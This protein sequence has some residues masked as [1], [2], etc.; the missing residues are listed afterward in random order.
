MS[1]LDLTKSS[2]AT[3]SEASA[4]L[5]HPALQRN[6]RTV[7]KPVEFRGLSLF[8]GYDTT[9]KLLPADANTGIVF[10]R[11]DICDQPDILATTEYL[12][13]EPR[14]TVLAS[15]RSCRVETV[16]HLMAA[17]AGLQIDNCVI[18]INTPEMPSY[19]G[20]SIAFC[21]GILDAGFDSLTENVDVLQVGGHQTVRSSDRKQSLTLRPYLFHCTAITYHFDYGPR[22]LVPPQ[23]LSVEITPDV[24]YAEIAGAR[25]FILESEIAGLKKLGFGQHLT[26]RDLVVIGKRGPIEN[27]LRWADEGVRH[28]ILDCVG[29]LAL[30]GS[31]FHGHIAASRS[32]HH[33]NHEMAK[34]LTMMKKSA[35]LSLK[36]A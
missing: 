5:T 15:S 8:H 33:L 29:D 2:K 19:D 7:C 14:R 26:T 20:S 4:F 9:V 27:S 18:E 24:F 31:G 25:T 30:C 1:A 12:V 16:E 10:R 22:S 28:K 13:T 11:T 34:V 32:G 35:S 6:Q 36:A 23:Q 3:V 17:L 21:D